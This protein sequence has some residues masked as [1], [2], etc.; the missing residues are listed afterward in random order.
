MIYSHVSLGRF[1]GG[2]ANK[3][4]SGVALGSPA[5]CA[6]VTCGILRHPRCPYGD[7]QWTDCAARH[8]N[9]EEDGG[10]GMERLYHSENQKNVTLALADI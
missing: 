2:K 7:R 3:R 10:R 1:G 9:P 6:A 4:R 5:S 8:G